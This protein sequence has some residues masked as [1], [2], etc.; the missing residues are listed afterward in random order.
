ME[1]R[2]LVV[3]GL[4]SSRLHI[5]DTKPDP[6]QLKIVKVIEPETVF[7]RTGYSRAHTSHCGPDGIYMNALGSPSGEGPGGVFMLDAETF[8]VRGRWE[9]DR[10]PQY[11]AYD[12][13]WHLG[14]D[15]MIT[16]EWGTP[17]MVEDGVNPELLLS[18]Q[19]GHKI[20]VWDLKSRKHIQELDLGSEYQM[21]LELRPAHDPSRDY[22]FV[23]VVV[24]LKDLSASVW[25][26]Y[27]EDGGKWAI[28]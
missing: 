9:Q 18:S 8:D 15:V 27:R 23:G 4:R 3:P 13:W 28:R 25:V 12:F 2:C 21:V 24:S 10:G 22:G 26:W 17:N 6:R 16:S 5:I 20:H 11:L 1:R 14:Y 19:Y 7:A